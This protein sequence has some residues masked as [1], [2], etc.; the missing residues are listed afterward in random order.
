MMVGKNLTD[1][2]NDG[3]REDPNDGVE[4]GEG[5]ER[6][7]GGDDGGN[8]TERRFE[9]VSNNGREKSQTSNLV[10]KR[11]E[12]SRLVPHLLSLNLVLMM[13]EKSRKVRTL[14]LQMG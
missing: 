10:L 2:E 1:W 14:A 4:D 13:E 9:L 3:G 5:D 6:N 7:V 11:G 8:K 12:K